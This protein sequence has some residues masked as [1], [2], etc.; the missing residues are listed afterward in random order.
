MNKNMFRLL[1]GQFVTV[2]GLYSFAIS[3]YILKETQSGLLFG[4]SLALGI[5]PQF[6]CSPFAG[7]ISDL[8][9]RKKIIVVTDAL[10]GMFL[11]L[12]FLI[13]RSTG[14]S[15]FY[16]YI[17]MFILAVLSVFNLI[18]LQAA[19][20]NAVEKELLP[21]LN[22]LSQSISSFSR[23]SAPWIGGIIILKINIQLFLLINAISFFIA[24]ILEYHI[25]FADCKKE[26]AKKDII[27]FKKIS[28]DIKESYQY[29]KDNSLIFTIL[30]F[31]ITMNFLFQFG[32]TVPVPY[33][34]NN[35]LM[36]SSR[37]YGIIQSM[38]SLGALITSLIMSSKFKVEKS[39]Q[40]LIRAITVM[41]LLMVFMGLATVY[42]EIFLNKNISFLF[43]TVLNFLFGG[44]I[45]SSNIPINVILQTSSDDSHR[46]R[47]MGLSSMMSS[48]IT[49]CAVIISG[50]LLDL[51]WLHSYFLCIGGGGILLIIVT[52]MSRRKE[53]QY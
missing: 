42:G 34:I 47:V 6:L 2:F 31:M 29:S 43:F 32:F 22:S 19:L 30:I 28:E 45:V 1:L 21:K 44:A 5:L 37:Q 41:S 40:L 38:T 7:V 10:S 33:I 48:A 20:P 17:L 13:S 27:N 46:G 53:M 4:V 23:I 11:M 8:Y 3:Y 12:V 36:L 26:T 18:A 39:K 24:S 15:I 49:P 16:I 25:V 35:T 52:I 51:N 9:E 50:I 14:M